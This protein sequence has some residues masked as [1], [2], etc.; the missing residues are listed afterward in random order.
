M[1]KK[2][3]ESLVQMTVYVC[4]IISHTRKSVCNIN[5]IPKED[6]VSRATV[7][8]WISLAAQKIL[9]WIQPLN[10]SVVQ[11]VQRIL[12]SKW[13]KTHGKKIQPA[14]KTTKCFS[15]WFQWDDFSTSW[16]CWK[17]LYKFTDS[18]WRF[19]LVSEDEPYIHTEERD[20]RF[21]IL[22]L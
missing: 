5:H 19:S 4:C 14:E 3:G 17:K 7:T 2:L 6:L 15:H 18:W 1:E 12:I 9:L 22:S 20:S 16:K 13:C 11:C 8:K 10:L 21:Y